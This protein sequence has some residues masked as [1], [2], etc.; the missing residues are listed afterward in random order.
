MPA[1][2]NKNKIAAFLIKEQFKD[3]EEILD[4]FDELSSEEIKNNE[5]LI[6][7]L[8]FLESKKCEPNWL[9]KFFGIDSLGDISFCNSNTRAVFLTKTDGRIFAIVFGYGKGL[10]KKDV[11]EDDFGLFTTLNLVTP[12]TLR[13]VD[14]V[15]LALSGK[16]TREQLI[17]SGEIKDF[18]IDIEQDLVNVVTG[19]CS[20]ETLGGIITGRDSFHVSVESDYK[21]IQSFL[22]EY[23]KYYKSDEYKKN[24]SWIN[25]IRKV[26]DKTIIS[27]L[28]DELVKKIKSENPEKIWLAVP[29]VIEWSGIE[30]FKYSKSS[31]EQ[32]EDLFLNDF[33]LFLGDKL[34]D[35]DIKKLKCY[36]NVFIVYDFTKSEFADWSIYSCLYCEISLGGNYYILNNKK[37]YKIDNNFVEDINK[38]FAL[39][40]RENLG[41]PNYEESV[42]AGKGDDKGEG[43]YNKKVSEADNDYILFDKKLISIGGGNNKIEFCDLFSKTHKRL[44]HVKI[45]GG[46]SV[47]SHL[48]NQGLVSGVLFLEEEMFREAVNQKLTTDCKL[49][50]V[51][52]KPSANDYQIVFAIISSSE[53]ELNL[54]FF[55]KIA[56][57]NVYKRLIS[58]NYKVAISKI[59]KV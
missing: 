8:Y 27:R 58:L 57:S 37:W 59:Q 2:K 47:L 53:D 19:K 31:D 15:D 21:E 56:L 18:G 55:S 54:P 3:S 20:M 52:I 23:L 40:P 46:S 12:D 33:K 42:F 30:G 13:S 9:K 5:E 48:F 11:F 28:D 26:D 49:S 35:L 32:F 51:K 16:K 44:V 36:Y 43:G 22:S 17:K 38:R 1:K 29:E 39:V 25:N 4:S 10:L 24:F 14:K 45:Y 50:D 6:G 41:L 34:D 7:T